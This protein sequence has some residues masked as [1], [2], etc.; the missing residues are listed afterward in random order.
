MTGHPPSRL[1]WPGPARLLITN[2]GRGAS[3][4]LIRSLRAGDPSLAI[5]G[6]HHD[7]FVLK[8]SDA[9]HNY[10]VPPAGHPRRISMLR[11]ILKTERVD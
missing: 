5:L 11:R 8:N 1:R 6:C 3:N 10:L 7:Q 2:A 4:N 9:D